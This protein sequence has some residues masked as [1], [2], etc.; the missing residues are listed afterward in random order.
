MRLNWSVFKINGLSLS[1]TQMKLFTFLLAFIFSSAYAQLSNPALSFS[2][3]PGVGNRGMNFKSKVPSA[4][5]DSINKADIWRQ[6]LSASAMLSYS[7]SRYSRIFTGVQFLNFGFTRMRYNLKFMDTIHPDIGIV[8]DLSQTGSND[9]AYIYRYQYLAFPF[10]FASKLK[11]KKLKTSTLHFMMGGS[12]CVLL[13]HD[14]KTKLIGFSAKGEKQ[15]KLKDKDNEAGLFNANI[16][17]GLRLENPI[18]NKNTFIFVQPE[19]Y[20]PVLKANYSDE[21]A[22]LYH[23]GLQIGMMYL[24]EKDKA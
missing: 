13:N 18:I 15:F 16:Q 4:Y 17:F 14:I 6:S 19:L 10:M 20:L 23:F 5:K 12:L 3:E 1:L 11:V 24:L 2:V 22:Q 8:N 7:T 9:V 21:K